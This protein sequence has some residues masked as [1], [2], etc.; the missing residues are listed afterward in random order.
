[1]IVPF[2]LGI[3]L[4]TGAAAKGSVT[5]HVKAVK[6]RVVFSYRG[7]TLTD[8]KLDQ[9]CATSRR[10]KA[11]IAFQKERMN[12]NDTMASLLREA[13][14]L[15]ATHASSGFMEIDRRSEPKPAAH[16][17]AKQRHKAAAPR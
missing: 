3:A 11:E 5:I 14:C 15:S 9:L 12:S 16:R 1:M 10:Q 6:G 8:S 7:K 2:I 13:Q 4:V 17:H